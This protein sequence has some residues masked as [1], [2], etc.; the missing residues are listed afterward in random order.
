MTTDA[1]GATPPA[2]EATRMF[3]ARFEAFPREVQ[4]RVMRMTAEA[5][6]QRLLAM[7]AL[8]YRMSGVPD[9]EAQY[10]AMELAQSEFKWCT[11]ERDV[12]PQ[13]RTE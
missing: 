1:T 9:H 5:F 4:E 7:I 10:R 13:G 2:G 12:L 11:V 6:T 8:A 3:E